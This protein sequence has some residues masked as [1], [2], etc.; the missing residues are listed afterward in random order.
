MIRGHSCKPNIYESWSISELGVG[1][2]C[3][4][5]GLIPP[6]KYFT[7]SVGGASFADYLCYFYFGCVMLLCTSI[8]SCLAVTCTE[9]ADLL[10]LVCDVLL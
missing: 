8:Y 5:T 9:R 1:L 3:R 10:P 7:D 6:V 4:E 2:T